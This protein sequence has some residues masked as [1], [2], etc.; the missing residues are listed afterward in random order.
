MGNFSEAKYAI[1]YWMERAPS[2]LQNLE[3]REN[4]IGAEPRKFK[5]LPRMP[6]SEQ[7]E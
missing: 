5:K 7:K 1:H 2:S 3:G 4:S 6:K